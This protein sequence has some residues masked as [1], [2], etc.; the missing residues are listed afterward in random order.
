MK[1]KAFETKRGTRYKCLATVSEIHSDEDLGFCVRCGS[2]A[3][4]VEPDARGYECENCGT[5]GIY[6]LEELMINGYLEIVREGE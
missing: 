4:G 3:Y 1:A 6:G 2:E 5:K